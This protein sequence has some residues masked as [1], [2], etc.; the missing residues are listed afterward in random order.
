MTS[1]LGAVLGGVA[2][3][4]IVLDPDR[5]LGEAD[6]VDLADVGDVVVISD[7]LEM[8][9]SYEIEG[10]HR[11]LDDRPLVMVVQSD[12]F[13]EPRQLPFDIEQRADVGRVRLAMADPVRSV[14]L[15]LPEEVQDVAVAAAGGADPLGRVLEAVWGV[16]LPPGGGSVVAELDAVVRLRTDPTVPT[17]L[18]PVIADRLRDPLAAGLALDP[19]DVSQ[20]QTAWEAWVAGGPDSEWAELFERIGPRIAALFH[21][22]MLSPV[23]AERSIPA[24]A[25]A[26]VSHPGWPSVAESLLASPPMEGAPVDLAGWLRLAEWWGEVRLAISLG[27]PDTADLSGASWAAWQPWDD[28]FREFLHNAFGK[29]LTSSAGRPQTI[30]KIAP[31]LARRLRDGHAKRVMLV[32]FDGMGFSSWSLL[33]REAGLKVV[34]ASGVLAMAPSL[35]PI[36]R[37][38]IFAGALPL[39]FSDC[40]GDTKKEGAMWR[41]FW[42][43]EGVSVTSVGYKNIEG[44]QAIEVPRFPTEQVVGVVVRAIDELMHTSEML[45]EA[46]FAANVQTW[47]KHGFVRELVEGASGDGFEVWFTAD[48]GG[49]EVVPSGRPMEGLAVDLVGTRV[50]LYPTEALRE[51]SKAEGDMWDPPGMPAGSHFALFPWGRDGMRHG[52]RVT[53]GGLSFDEMIV[54]FV[55]VEP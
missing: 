11:P 21:I 42:E 22:G 9:R 26:G 52:V 40:F 6:L 39:T 14:V 27:A 13:R 19:P 53:H 51:Q 4:R 12:D 45:G 47:L 30:N 8:R 32:V 10:R 35:T 43:N 20:L 31:Y 15:A 23:L 7:W 38:A 5:V 37:Q 46:Q 34:D 3:I 25:V 55:R 29:L 28:A 36:S 49:V 24:W 48:H 33:R 16:R 17:E 41:H 44:I 18:W 2:S 50:R 54:P 1:R